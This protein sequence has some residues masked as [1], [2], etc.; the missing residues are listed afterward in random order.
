MPVS[1]QQFVDSLSQ[2]G[3]MTAAEAGEFVNACP[4]GRRPADGEGLAQRLVQAG[5]LTRYQAAAIVQGRG[6]S[7]VFDEYVIL[8]KL[9]QGGMGV[10]LKAEH[11]RMKRLVAIKVIA[12]ATMR[13][14]EAVKRFYR[15]V[16]AAARLEHANIVT[17]Y[18][19]RQYAGSHCLVMQYVDGKD[20]ANI[21]K[22][23]GPLPVRQAVECVLQAAQGL[24][25]AHEQGI[26]HRDIKPGN[27]LLDRK[28]TVKI[29]DMGLARIEQSATAES[30]GE[31]L[32]QSGQIM[33][34][35]DYMAP[36]QALDTHTVDA[37][38]DIYSLGCT[39]YRLLTGKT[40]YQAD[41]FAKLF[42]AHLNDPIPSLCEARPD[43]PADLDAVYRKM[44]AKRPEHR[45]QSMA[46]VIAELERVLGGS[47]SETSEDSLSSG[48]LSFL[49]EMTHG[50]TGTRVAVRAKHEETLSHEAHP[51][52][53]TSSRQRML[54]NVSR[55]R[56][57]VALAVV[58]IALLAT[59]T[60]GVIITLRSRDGRTT[61]I[62][63]PEGS[64]VAISREGNVDVTRPASG[65]AG[66]DKE[67]RRYEKRWGIKSF[68]QR[69]QAMATVELEGHS[70]W[71]ERVEDRDASGFA[72][73][74]AINR[75]ALVARP[76]ALAGVQAWTIDTFDHPG[77]IRTLAFSPDGRQFASGSYDGKIIVWDVQPGKPIK[78]VRL[79]LRHENLYGLAWSSDGRM[80]ASAGGNDGT[81]RLW[82]MPAGLLVRTRA[83][84]AW[85]GTVAWSPDG[86]FLMIGLGF[87]QEPSDL[88]IWDWQGNEPPRAVP[89]M[90]FVRHVQ[91][92]PDGKL[93]AGAISGK[94]AMV[95]IWQ[96]PSLEPVHALQLDAGCRFF[97][98]SP[99][100]R[101]LAALGGKL[102]VWEAA[103]G[104]AHEG[105]PPEAGD[106]S[107]PLAWIG[108]GRLA[109]ALSGSDLIAWDCNAR[110]SSVL[111]KPP[112]GFDELAVSSDGLTLVVGKKSGAVMVHRKEA[113]WQEFSSRS[114][115]VVAPAFSPDGQ[116]LACGVAGQG[117][118][119]WKLT[120]DGP[121]L[122]DHVVQPHLVCRETAWSGD[123]RTLVARFGAEPRFY[124]AVSG[125]RIAAWKEDQTHRLALS[126]DG[127][128][129][130]TDAGR[131]TCRE[132]ASGKIVWQADVGGSGAAW[133]PDGASIAAGLEPEVGV[134]NAADGR[135]ERRLA[136]CQPSEPGRSAL[137]VAW[138]AS[139]KLVAAMPA[140]G[141][142]AIWEV[143]TG[144]Q[145]CRMD[146][147][148]AFVLQWADHDRSVLGA[149]SARAARWDAQSGKQQRTYIPGQMNLKDISLSSDGRLAAVGY[150]GA[151]R[152]QRLADG[153]R[154]RSVLFLP[155]DRAV[156][157]SPEGH[158]AGPPGV[159]KE[160]VY[161][162]QT[163]T[164]QDTLT[165]EEFSRK[166]HWKND[167][168]QALRPIEL[169]PDGK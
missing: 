20:L 86:R 129:A 71:A 80:L 95:R 110:Q 49:K 128:R 150:G 45:Q 94:P 75:R 67:M 112:S 76:T 157:I 146:S 38:A 24:R 134:F 32:T 141:S 43:V 5:R 46:E 107:G 138:S 10:V 84:R 133:S 127:R 136:G 88:Q 39:L 74:K 115:S 131:L 48:A 111:P 70:G 57:L 158:Y 160:L 9:G 3:L 21:V 142:G 165:P 108:R 132:V 34:T 140:M 162:V 118:Y 7:L 145:V 64:Q 31:R 99:D 85:P 81:L 4:P 35:C 144:R 83:F 51:E 53:D 93:I 137:V 1:I 159:E 103:S 149:N 50:A 101:Y 87:S 55:R 68:D 40:P 77:E 23:H 44:M 33:G 164:G 113:G 120:S 123:G 90:R 169:A 22:E 36:E 12:P 42:L 37:R 125:K 52:T 126:P 69:T 121:Q 16:E 167:P 143:S 25:Y 153:V 8:D 97:A 15:E 151:V 105:L 98:W 19:A 116:T 18:D 109:F 63:V 29:L 130:V 28:G 78:P 124:D 82:S 114:D 117:L 102:H 61:T 56:P 66:G 17:A 2:S 91:W 11:R 155:N 47:G 92:S 106:A 27:L 30:G 96:F 166:Y 163:E 168:A 161:V 6:K 135:L 65:S 13:S 62:E 58:G 147:D 54:L 72:P 14:P 60:L 89:G 73:G 152:L 104:R 122:L 41:S 26:V 59:V 119:R 139:G 154:L 79:L 148:S 156:T 100:G